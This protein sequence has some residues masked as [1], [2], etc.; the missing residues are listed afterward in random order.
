MAK[1]QLRG[2]RETKKPKKPK[3]PVAAPSF[4]KGSPVSLGPPKKK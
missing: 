1:G 3:E 2:N 4:I